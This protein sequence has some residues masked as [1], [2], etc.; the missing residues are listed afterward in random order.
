M[1]LQ[2][3][4]DLGKNDGRAIGRSS[5][6]VVQDGSVLFVAHVPSRC[7][8]EAVSL[9]NRSIVARGTPSAHAAWQVAEKQ[10]CWRKP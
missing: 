4:L 3:K 9:R 10:P 5:S 1:R 7:G 2:P 8:I 6:R